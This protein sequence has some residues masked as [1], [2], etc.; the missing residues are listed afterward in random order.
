MVYQ[1]ERDIFPDLPILFEHSLDMQ[2][3]LGNYYEGN[4]QIIFVMKMGSELKR[5]RSYQ[6][7]PGNS[8]CGHASSSSSG[9]AGGR[10]SR[11][12]PRGSKLRWPLRG[13]PKEKVGQDRGISAR[14]A[15]HACFRQQ[16]G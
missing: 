12:L 9:R 2:L 3:F 4:L 7:V 10:P 5:D 16:V 8:K 6:K 13:D 11:P 1:K 15:W 14:R